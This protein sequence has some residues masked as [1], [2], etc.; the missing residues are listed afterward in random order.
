MTPENLKTRHAA[1]VRAEAAAWIARLQGPNRSA[2]VEDGLRRWLGDNPEHAAAFERLT[3]TWEKSTRLWRRPAERVANWNL[4][5][6]RIRFSQA[7]LA[8]TM[9]CMCAIIATV[10]YL[11]SDAITTDIGEL[12]TV[13]LEDGTRVHLNTA[14][15][16]RV[17]YDQGHRGVALEKGEAVFEVAHRA[18]WPFVVTAAGRQIRALG[19]QFV[20]RSDA[21]DLIVT[22]IQGKVDVSPVPAAPV[23]T[24]VAT[25]GPVSQ[26][27]GASAAPQV[28]RFTLTPGERLTFAQAK[29]PQID[30]PSLNGITA[31]ER[32]QVTFDDIPLAAAAG[33]LNRYS[34][35]RIVLADPAIAAIHV[36][37]V[38]ATGDSASFSQAV[39]QA[40]HLKVSES[41]GEII[42]A[43]Q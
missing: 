22:L 31:W 14:T 26:P 25:S 4:A 3:E 9:C 13:T 11:H 37:G 32:G 2:E 5:G 19:T 34:R 42:L 10:L 39:A 38:F 28:E 35:R 40:F 6:F 21:R 43:R 20:V 30:W 27:A 36:S 8:M 41:P 15:R 24:A 23:V 7:A 16:V 33:E 18:D 17:H 12:R 1:A 29:S